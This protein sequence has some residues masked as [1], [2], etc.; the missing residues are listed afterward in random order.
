MINSDQLDSDSNLWTCHS[1][2]KQQSWMYICFIL[3]RPKRMR[4]LMWV[5]T[6]FIVLVGKI[7]FFLSYVIYH[8]KL[9]CKICPYLWILGLR[10][11]TTT[12][13]ANYILHLNIIINYTFFPALYNASSKFWGVIWK[14][15]WFNYSFWERTKMFWFTNTHSVCLCYWQQHKL[16]TLWSKK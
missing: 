1:P 11:A 8:I 10:R 7:L 16:F 15:C 13:I 12:K 5:L 14:N 4:P 9:T 6:N 2:K 3:T